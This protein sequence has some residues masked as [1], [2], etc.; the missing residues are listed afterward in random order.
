ME[1]GKDVKFRLSG[2]SSEYIGTVTR[3]IP[4]DE[5]D[6][7]MPPERN[8]DYTV[9]AVKDGRVYEVNIHKHEIVEVME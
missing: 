6:P 3:V 7:R 1:I 4:E 8:F 2:M 5:K 9:D